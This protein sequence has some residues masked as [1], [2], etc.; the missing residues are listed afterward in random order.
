M[1]NRLTPIDE[2]REPIKNGVRSSISLLFYLMIFSGVVIAFIFFTGWAYA[3]HYFAYFKVGLL[4][5]NLPLVT[6][7]G[8][9]FWVFQAWWWLF[10]PYGFFVGILVFLEPRFSDGWTRI[11]QD[12]PLLLLHLQVIA[13]LLAFLLAWWITALSAE[14]FFRDQQ[15]HRFSDLPRVS[16][17][18][19]ERPADEA[20]RVLYQELPQGVYRLL[21]GNR[22]RL[23]LFKPPAEGQSFPGPV[24]E[25]PWKEIKLVQV[26]P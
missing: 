10:L 18:P 6:Y 26:F 7:P 17:W 3:Y 24:I 1:E 12:R 22:N 19:N 15:A 11:K 23:F 25:L 5:L 20:L 16:V 2:T 9:C 4:T 21:L 8:F 14:R 13:T